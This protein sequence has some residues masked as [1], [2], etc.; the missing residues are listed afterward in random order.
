MMDIPPPPAQ[1]HSINTAQD[2]LM[3][4]PMLDDSGL[5]RF[6]EFKVTDVIP[7][8]DTV[9]AEADAQLIQIEKTENPSWETIMVPLETLLQ[10]L[11]CV[12]GPISHLKGV[13]DSPELRESWQAVE[14][15]I[16]EFSL[17]LKQSEPLFRH[18]KALQEKSKN[19]SPVQ[20][21]ILDKYVLEAHLSGIDLEREKKSEFNKIQTRLAEIQSS[22]NNHVLDSITRFSLIVTDKKELDGLPE[23]FQ[24][25]ASQAYNHENKTTSSTPEN[26]PWKLSLE[27]TIF[28]ATIKYCSSGSL[29]EKLYRAHITRASSGDIDNTPLINEM[30]KLRKRSAELLGYQ[31]YAEVSLALKMAPGV[32]DVDKL[33]ENLRTASWQ[34]G[35]AEL[36]KITAFAAEQ[37]GSTPLKNWD[38][39]YWSERY[40]EKNLNLNEEELRPYFQF[41]KVL[42]GL[43]DLTEKLFS[44]KVQ[45][46]PTK[47]ATWHPDVKYYILTDLSG[48]QIAGL[49]LDPYSRPENKRGGAWMDNCRDRHY[50]NGKLQIPVAYNCCNMPPPVNG[51]PSLMT[52]RE[53]E[54]LFHEF[55]HALQHMLTTVDFSFVSGINGI[56]WDAVEIASQ[57]M[58]NWCYHK[59]TLLGMT[60]HI[61]TKEPLP[62]HH[63]ETLVKNRKY[64]AASAMLRQIGL[65]MLDIE[66]HH[67][68]DPNGTLSVQDISRQIAAKTSHLPYFE[69]ERFLCSFQHIFSGGYSAGYYSYKWAEVFSCDAFEAFE[70]AGLDNQSAIV[71]VGMRYRNTLLA[72]GGSRDPMEV[73]KEFRKKPPTEEALLRKHGL[74]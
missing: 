18:I 73:Y 67:R 19:L 68:F 47:V 64:M 34:S 41:P 61:E 31:S 45:E 32:S 57:F 48:K 3:N 40:K 29:R 36:E 39:T 62:D 54:T 42:Q 22:Y 27:P 35:K 74:K 44:I 69:D 56:E 16:V 1:I 51:K 38:I 70:E 72:Y 5:P 52:F 26:G 7:A 28:L 9:L 60:E 33:H 30:L 2:K 21:R 6:D 25:L 58:E 14:P 66:L 17:K 24:A 50:R 12:I 46:C 10:R 11:H 71:E 15:K 53:V 20:K 63:Y 23:S 59:P 37:G 55:G 49:Y 65:G 43:F 13:Q 4:N 8:V